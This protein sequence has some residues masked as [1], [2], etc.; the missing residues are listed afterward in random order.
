MVLRAYNALVG[1]AAATLL[2]A[3]ASAQVAVQPAQDVGAA[4]AVESI[5]E[6][7]FF[8]RIGFLAAD[9]LEGRDTPS[10]GLEVAAEYIASEFYRMG[11]E[12]AGDAGTYFQR[13]PYT[14]HSLDAGA[15]R[16]VLQSGAER[17][18]LSLGSDYYVAP[19]SA[20]PFSGGIVF[21]GEGVPGPEVRQNTLRDRVAA[22]HMTQLSVVAVQRARNA[23]DSAGAAAL[24]VVLPQDVAE[25]TIRNATASMG[26]QFRAVPR[27]P[28]FY[29]RHDR[30]RELFRDASL[31][32]DALNRAGGTP[33]PVA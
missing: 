25:E 5:H 32:F 24:L 17:R 28:V 6:R 15:T 30:G 18:A 19:G 27:L 11:L 23:A 13:W 7:D 3:C 21:V 10:R 1:A 22:I 29:L 20:E 33:R 31:D 16:L 8:A 12:P 4:A 2:T 9:A 14:T 26:R